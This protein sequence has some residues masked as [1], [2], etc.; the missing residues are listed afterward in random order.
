MTPLTTEMKSQSLSRPIVIIEN[1]G[2]S[3]VIFG[4]SIQWGAISCRLPYWSQMSAWC[5]LHQPRKK[6]LNENETIFTAF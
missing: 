5:V 3:Q 1:W 6:F 4:L 2:L